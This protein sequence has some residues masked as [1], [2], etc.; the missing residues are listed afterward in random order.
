MTHALTNSG[1]LAFAGPIHRPGDAGY[2]AGRAAFNPNLDARPLAVAEATSAEDVRAAIAWSRAHEVPFA[3]QSTGHGTHVASD[4]GLLLKTSRLGTVLVDPDRRI[5]RIGAGARWSD[6]LAAAAPFGLAPLSGSSPEV[7][8]AGYTLGGGLS[9][10]SRR[11][12]FAADSL[13]RAELVTA[14]GRLVTASPRLNPELF[15]ALR[16]GGGNFGV[17]TSMDIRLH[18]VDS[19]FVGT[20]V[21]PFTTAADTLDRYRTWTQNIPDALSTAVVLLPS[22]PETPGPVFAIRCMYAGEATAA[23]K[24]LAPLYREAGRAIWEDFGQTPFAEARIPGTAP[25]NVE[26]FESL[27]D[28]VIDAA[29][30]AVDDYP[31]NAVEIRHWGGAMAESGAPIAARDAAFSIIVDGPSEA[32]D[33]IRPYATGDQFLNFLA[34]PARVADAYGPEDLPRLRQIK[35]HWDPC[36]VF[37]VNHNIRPAGDEFRRSTSSYR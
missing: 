1:D 29:L 6:V 35:N 4:G 37:N 27:P 21:F 23:V 25:R 28:E 5:A 22:W 14:D 32:V 15:W 34:D 7:G 12:G 10:L 24:A 16:G 19:V 33:E 18:Q 31:V 2:D 3:V 11:Y 30:D 36:N 8:V 9:W 26:L 17:V 13:L 20:A